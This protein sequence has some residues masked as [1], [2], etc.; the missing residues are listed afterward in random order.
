MSSPEHTG[1]F[2]APVDTTGSEVNRLTG[3]EASR[4]SGDEALVS[5]IRKI[6]KDTISRFNFRYLELGSLDMETA[7]EEAEI[8]PK[9]P[10]NPNPFDVEF[11]EEQH[12]LWWEEHPEEANAFSQII[13]ERERIL[14]LLYL[15]A[16]LHR[17]TKGQLYSSQH[18]P[19]GS[20]AEELRKHLRAYYDTPMFIIKNGFRLSG[21]LS[22]LEETSIVSVAQE[23][24]DEWVN[25]DEHQLRQ[26]K[27]E[28]PEF[29]QRE[30]ILRYLYLGVILDQMLKISRSNT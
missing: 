14:D 25:W 6:Q 11:A 30:E 29:E 18:V 2:N 24:P 20:T 4:G 16:R 19:P 8:L 15:G 12:E 3:L 7:L 23:L 28:N 22:M 27:E 10:E 1:V 5:Q 21:M 9:T 17:L 13:D 26:W